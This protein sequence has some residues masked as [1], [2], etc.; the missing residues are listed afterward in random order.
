MIHE[1]WFAPSEDWPLEGQRGGFEWMPQE[2]PGVKQW[3]EQE[4]KVAQLE[5]VV[6]SCGME[7]EKVNV[8]EADLCRCLCLL[9]ADDDGLDKYS[10]IPHL[11]IVDSFCESI[12][13]GY[14][15]TVSLLHRL[16]DSN[17]YNFAVFPF[18]YIVRSVYDKCTRV[19]LV[20]GSYAYLY[21]CA[22][23]DID[24]DFRFKLVRLFS[25]LMSVEMSAPVVSYIPQSGDEIESSKA[26]ACS[27]Y[28]TNAEHNVHICKKIDSKIQDV[29]NRDIRS[30]KQRKKQLE[31]LDKLKKKKPNVYIPHGGNI[32]EEFIKNTKNIDIEQLAAIVEKM[33]LI[34]FGIYKGSTLV[35]IL[36]GLGMMASGSICVTAYK[37]L[38]KI[39]TEGLPEVTLSDT[40]LWIKQ[41]LTDWT[42]FRNNQMA[43]KFWA[44][45]MSIFTFF[46]SPKTLEAL[47]A[48]PLVKWANFFCKGVFKG[49]IISTLLSSI[50]YLFNAIRV[51][52][53]TGS[54]SGFWSTDSTYDGIVDRM[55]SL[56]TKNE[57]YQ[58]GNLSLINVD[59]LTFFQEMDDMQVE[60]RK[61]RDV[62]PPHQNKMVFAYENEM[63]LMRRNVYREI[64]SQSRQMP[65]ILGVFGKSGVRKTHFTRI[66]ARVIT[67]AAGHVFTPESYTVLDYKKKYYDGWKNCTTVIG[68]E[69]V[70]NEIPGAVGSS[71][72]AMGTFQECLI[73]LGGMEAFIL[74]AAALP[75]KNMLFFNG[76]GVVFNTNNE[77]LNLYADTMFV[78]TGVR[79]VHSKVNL[80]IKREYR[81]EVAPGEYSS[82]ADNSK[83]P[84]DI[85]SAP[86]PDIWEIDV[87]VAEVRV[88]SR[89][90][91]SDVKTEFEQPSNHT[92]MDDQ[93]RW[94]MVKSNICLGEYIEWLIES[95]IEHRSQ[96]EKVVQIANEVATTSRCVLCG[97]YPGICVCSTRPMEDLVPL[98]SVNTDIHPIEEE[99]VNSDEYCTRLI[100]R[101]RQPDVCIQKP[102]N[103]ELIIESDS[104]VQQ[105]VD[106]IEELEKINERLRKQVQQVECK[107]E[108]KKP[109]RRKIM[110]QKYVETKYEPHDGELRGYMDFIDDVLQLEVEDSDA[111][112]VLLNGIRVGKTAV[113]H[114]YGIMEKF[115]TKTFSTLVCLVVNKLFVTLGLG[116]ML[117]MKYWIPAS[118]E[119]TVIGQYL[120]SQRFDVRVAVLMDTYRQC[121]GAPL[122]YTPALKKGVH[123][124]KTLLGYKPGL[125]GWFGGDL[126]SSKLAFPTCSLL[127][128][129]NL[130][131]LYNDLMEMTSAEL[132]Y[133]EYERKTQCPDSLRDVAVPIATGWVLA[134][135]LAPQLYRDIRNI[136]LTTYLPQGGA[137]EEIEKAD[138]TWNAR[139]LYEMRTIDAIGLTD[140]QLAEATSVAPESL[141]SLI[142]NNLVYLRCGTKFVNGFIMTNQ[143]LLVPHHFAKSVQGQLVDC[144]RYPS[145]GIKFP[146]NAKCSFILDLAEGVPIRGQDIIALR[147]PSIGTAR[148]IRKNLLSEP[149]SSFGAWC[150]RLYTKDVACNIT[151]SDVSQLKHNPYLSNDPESHAR[152]MVGY[153]YNGKCNKGMCMSPL[154]DRNTK[155]GKIMGFHI[156]GTPDGSQGIATCFLQSHYDE[157]LQWLASKNIPHVPHSGGFE[158]NM[159]KYGVCNYT[160]DLTEKSVLYQ[161][162]KP[163]VVTLGSYRKRV[164]IK[165][166]FQYTAIGEDYAKLRKLDFGCSPVMGPNGDDPA[167]P[168]KTATLLTELDK[169]HIPPDALRWA[170]DDYLSG[171]KTELNKD[172]DVWRRELR[173]LRGMSEILGGIPGK[174][175]VGPMNLSTAVCPELGGKKRDYVTIKGDKRYL[176]PTI[177]NQY[178]KMRKDAR[179][180]KR[181]HV[182]WA[183]YPKVEVV[184]RRKIVE[185][186]LRIFYASDFAFQMLVR[187]TFGTLPRF[188]YIMRRASECAVGINPHSPAWTEIVEAFKRLKGENHMATDVSKFDA[189]MPSE[190]TTAADFVLC[191]VLRWSG[192]FDEADMNQAYVVCEEMTNGIVCVNGDMWMVNGTIMSGT[193]LTS[194]KGS[195]CNSIIHRVA[196]FEI[197][198]KVPQ[199]INLGFRHIVVLFTFGDDSDSKVDPRYP[200]YNT[201][202]IIKV[203]GKMGLKLTNCWKDEREVKYLKLH[204]I[205]FLKRK[206]VYMSEYGFYV[207]RLNEESIHKMLVGVIPN[208]NVHIDKITAQNIDT[209]L[210]EWRYYGKNIYNR[211]RA[212]LEEM[213]KEKGILDM[214]NFI[215]Y[216]YDDMLLA[217]KVANKLDVSE[218]SPTLL[219]KMQEWIENFLTK[220]VTGYQFGESEDISESGFTDTC[221]QKN[222]CV[223]TQKIIEIENNNCTVG[224]S[225]DLEEESSSLVSQTVERRIAH[226]AIRESGVAHQNGNAR[227]VLEYEPH[228]GIDTHTGSYDEPTT[229]AD[230]ETEGKSVVTTEIPIK[231]PKPPFDTP[232]DIMCRPVL[233]DSFEWGSSST[234]LFRKI[235]PIQLLRANPVISQRL[236]KLCFFRTKIHMKI[237]INGGPFYYGRMLCAYNPLRAPPGNTNIIRSYTDTTIYSGSNA[238]GN[239][240]LT[241]LPHVILDPCTSKGGELIM[242]YT[243]FTATSPISNPS[244][245]TLVMG[246]LIFT[247]LNPL[248]S[249]NED[250]AVSNQSL[251]VTTYAWFEDIELIGQ[252]TE[253]ADPFFPQAGEISDTLGKIADTCDT[254]NSIVPAV[255]P[256]LAPAGQVI[257]N[258]SQLS[259]AF[260]YT[261]D[262]TSN[263]QLAYNGLNLDVMKVDGVERIGKVSLFSK[264]QQSVSDM[265]GLDSGLD[266]LA[267][268]T[269]CGKESYIGTAVWQISSAAGTPLAYISPNLNEMRFIYPQGSV[270][271]QQALVWMTPGYAVAQMFRY[272][273]GVMRLRFE[274]VCSEY[275]KGRLLLVYDPLVEVTT[276][277]VNTGYQVIVDLAE[278]RVVE[279]DIGVNTLTGVIG[280]HQVLERST[281]IQSPIVPNGLAY[282]VRS[283]PYPIARSN[284]GLTIFVLNKLGLPTVLP[285]VNQNVSVNV[286]MKMMP[287]TKFFSP[288]PVKS[289][290][291]YEQHAGEVD[292]TDASVSVTHIDNSFSGVDRIMFGE[293]TVSLRALMK[294]PQTYLVCTI[295]SNYVTGV[296]TN[297]YQGV[298]LEQYPRIRGRYDAGNPIHLDT[299]FGGCDVVSNNVISWL[300]PAFLAMTG[301]V[302]WYFQALPNQRSVTDDNASSGYKDKPGYNIIYPLEVNVAG[303]ATRAI[304]QAYSAGTFGSSRLQNVQDML[305]RIITYGNTSIVPTATYNSG[306][307]ALETSGYRSRLFEYSPIVGETESDE[308]SFA[309]ERQPGYGWD[310]LQVS[311]AS[312]DDFNLSGFIGFPPVVYA[313]VPMTI[314]QS[315]LDPL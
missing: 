64:V 74:P 129:W 162:P 187:E 271:G 182:I 244:Y 105:Y 223:S 21:F 205:D 149:I 296:S 197:Y 51:F 87:F 136:F 54:L 120:H 293:G 216:S 201:S 39:V 37:A 49:D 154:I 208:K 83:I 287:G 152:N 191:E 33:L 109:T 47:S 161:N 309:V 44:L 235:V 6:Y 312:G 24:I 90:G 284:G 231:L 157:V 14:S 88:L 35:K 251:T 204:E 243:Y 264:T 77:S 99:A 144:F 311:V 200:E 207:G 158:E 164:R 92:S 229:F 137:L 2:V 153:E 292:T 278:T 294:R 133:L 189:S 176:D 78:S 18:G 61:L 107:E 297:E 259:A 303:P 1:T 113:Q 65:Y 185:G 59:T 282:P 225:I 108:I 273:T 249:V 98:D 274:V 193:N 298:V 3:F 40:M 67:E 190:I 138:N 70:A 55:L 175:Y 106:Y 265:V 132:S 12:N 68:L 85:N 143:V 22:A 102:E 301:S 310:I 79:R 30:S 194:L 291:H 276:R 272:Y 140:T 43:G 242:P 179:D 228:A 42:A 195:V 281:S 31:D 155:T 131:K 209:A 219:S 52:C 192:N 8:S 250:L 261:R 81:K 268:D 289:N 211:E 118:V 53:K 66:C 169:V 256:V 122:K 5:D 178:Q 96:Q 199:R 48:V 183:G 304:V 56:K 165:P 103:D 115:L 94:K 248:R 25:T 240:S 315:I 270:E 117:E 305:A 269:M 236:S 266:P 172:P 184:P 111:Y 285:A 212:L 80:R 181:V 213:A 4:F 308:G 221:P 260:G 299:V 86:F 246:E 27:K 128:N 283:V 168:N 93:W 254:V 313:D 36:S 217:W 148:D 286:Y 160:P 220:S 13:Q 170:V 214:C 167:F 300:R 82:M 222:G 28:R 58:S 145:S 46:V 130:R 173:P 156:G 72:S 166:Q 177:Y 233:I 142:S 19:I 262:K 238:L 11:E 50:Y 186:K 60:L 232:T 188:F 150:G 314:D 239:A 134:K 20:D 119:G 288:K 41:A 295:G 198:R 32:V 10:E 63:E 141:T 124:V 146:V 135:A 159:T 151:Q 257:R 279:M 26:Y 45:L 196:M 163:H 7:F 73:R 114:L 110:P 306:R 224:H 71:N 95:V 307:F 263:D 227:N 206:F 290:W 255:A 230:A 62:F 9:L 116:H 218:V 302:R 100:G 57:L 16:C 247:T 202:S 101:V 84:P 17:W 253:N 252:T 76:V 75:L 234:T 180:L 203:M 226:D 104:N 127:L 139:E 241:N 171:L 174:K 91:R 258:A 237:L 69:D 97:K 121:T 147:V 210:M 125:P 34:Y 123:P 280:D 23:A 112:E 275:H 38:L 89:D 245:A 29:L 277:P 215:K 267:I 126:S 15:P